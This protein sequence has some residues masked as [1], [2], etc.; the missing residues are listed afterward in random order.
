MHIA[1][2]ILAHQSP[3]HLIRL[4]H[5]LNKTDAHVDFFLHIDA[6][7]D[8]SKFH[9]ISLTFENVR[10][11]K[12]P[13]KIFWGGFSIVRAT[14]LLMQEALQHSKFDR[15]VLLSGCDYPIKPNAEIMSFF[16][17]HPDEQFINIVQMPHKKRPISRLTKYHFEGGTHRNWFIRG[18]LKNKINI[19][20]A[21][22]SYNRNYKKYLKNN[23]PYAGEQ[24]FSFTRS[25]VKL[26]L[27]SIDNSQKLV[28]FYKNTYVPDEMFF[29]TILMNLN[30]PQ[31]VNPGL[32]FC[33]WWQPYPPY[34][35]IICNK[36]IERFKKGQF[37]EDIYGQKQRFYARKFDGKTFSILDRI[38][39]ELLRK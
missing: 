1:Y 15:M 9:K 30:P 13:V 5:A 38:D 18:R 6:K 34:P 24:W 14:I 33:D 22:H 35:A 37:R 17:Q 8:R 11:L 19:W 36:H 7:S 21:K 4:I 25:C 28:N 16:Q 20:L 26:I 23:V 31:I 12:K 29:H 10:I 39:Q 3:E 27:K 2:L 32:V